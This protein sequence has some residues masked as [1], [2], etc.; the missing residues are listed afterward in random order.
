MASEIFHLE[1]SHSLARSV[2]FLAVPGSNQIHKQWTRPFS[3]TGKMPTPSRAQGAENS[4]G[5]P[6]TP[7]CWRKRT[8][9]PT[10]TSTGRSR[11]AKW[12]SPSLTGARPGDSRCCLSL[13]QP[14]CC[15][16]KNLASCSGMGQDAS[17][18]WDSQK[19]QVLGQVPMD[20]RVTPSLLLT[21]L[22]L[23]KTRPCFQ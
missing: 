6:Q 20:P 3:F 21:P 18:R 1:E 17:S 22:P 10:N 16:V 13:P 7:R 5:M 14:S 15:S 9:P 23:H 2:E 19:Y 4:P 11:R 8:Q 12:K